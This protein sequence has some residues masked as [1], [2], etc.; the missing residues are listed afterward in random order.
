MKM[1]LSRPSSDA[2]DANDAN[3]REQRLNQ[4]SGALAVARLTYQV[5]EL[6]LQKTKQDKSVA[7]KF[8]PLKAVVYSRLLKAG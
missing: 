7:P 6:E 3:D 8:L 1:S 4:L 5:K 2:S